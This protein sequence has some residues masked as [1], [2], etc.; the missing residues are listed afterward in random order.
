MMKK[1]WNTCIMVIEHDIG[2]LEKA[3]IVISKLWSL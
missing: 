1:V 3:S 2:F